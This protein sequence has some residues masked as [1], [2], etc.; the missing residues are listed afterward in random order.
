MSTTT[1]DPLCAKLL[2][3]R[4]P[5]LAIVNRAHG[6]VEAFCRDDGEQILRV[7]LGAADLSTFRR[8]QTVVFTKLLR[9]LRDEQFEQP[10]K[11]GR[12][13]WLDAVGLAVEL[14]REIAQQR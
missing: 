7:M 13:A 2:S 8:F 14:G 9:L 10:G 11:R 3:V 6:N 5:L 12:I 1:N 4:G